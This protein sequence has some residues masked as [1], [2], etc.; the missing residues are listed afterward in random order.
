MRYRSVDEVLAA[1]T[2]GGEFEGFLRRGGSPIPLASLLRER[3][4]GQQI[5]LRD[6]AV[7][8]G[9]IVGEAGD[10]QFEAHC[11]VFTIGTV[12]AAMAV[13]ERGLAAAMPDCELMWTNRTPDW[14]P[15][16]V[17]GLDRKPRYIALAD[18]VTQLA[19]RVEGMTILERSAGHSSFQLHMAIPGLTEDFFTKFGVVIS[20]AFTFQAD[21][22]AD[23]A[24]RRFDPGYEPGRRQ[25]CWGQALSINRGPSI[26]LYR[27]P[28]EL[29]ADWL[30]IH[31]LIRP[32]DDGYIVDLSCPES[33]EE[34]RQTALYGTVWRLV[35]FS[36][37]CADK[38]ATFE[39][40]I[41]GSLP[42]RA[43]PWLF[44]RQIVP[45]LR[46]AVSRWLAS[47]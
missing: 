26:T 44:E 12:A 14:P 39:I 9:N 13:F 2:F 41:W 31:R 32:V 40:R 33:L 43:I 22:F 28:A 24:G 35:R 8:A 46:G 10:A 3:G 37:A 29:A 5:P 1:A 25:S 6:G 34:V 45:A 4:D 36:P 42:P 11:P 47:I 27:S 23:E 15:R 21:E 18:A 20:N 38:P 16:L 7:P 19:G 30:S 17:A